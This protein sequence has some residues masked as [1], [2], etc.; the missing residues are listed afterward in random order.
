MWLALYSL[1]A[2]GVTWALCSPPPH[3]FLSQDHGEVVSLAAAICWWPST[4][5]VGIHGE[6]PVGSDTPGGAGGPGMNHSLRS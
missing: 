6:Y 4:V 3:V 5:R 2:P 1:E